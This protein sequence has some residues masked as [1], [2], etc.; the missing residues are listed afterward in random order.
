MPKVCVLEIPDKT[1][2]SV[3]KPDFKKFVG[4]SYPGFIREVD[5]AK[6]W[7]FRIAQ[8]VHTVKALEINTSAEPEFLKSWGSV[9]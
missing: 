9:H 2:M 3:K 6:C 4:V 8:D 5:A 1:D 7:I